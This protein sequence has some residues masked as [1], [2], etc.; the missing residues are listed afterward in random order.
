MKKNLMYI[1]LA[2]LFCLTIGV[3][4]YKSMLEEMGSK[5]WSQSLERERATSYIGCVKK[6]I[7]KREGWKDTCGAIE[8]V[9]E[10]IR[11][12]RD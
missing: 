10:N 6:N 3:C 2:F 4:I 1:F 12:N 5:D 8:V 11:K 9:F 7:W